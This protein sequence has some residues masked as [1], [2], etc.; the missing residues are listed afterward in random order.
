MRRHH[1][2]IAIALLS[3]LACTGSAPL[4]QPT[5]PDEK[6]A[7]TVVVN[8]PL[9]L[10]VT[11]FEIVGIVGVTLLPGRVKGTRGAVRVQENSGG[12]LC[13]IAITGHA[14]VTA[15][16]VVLHIDDTPRI[17]H[18]AQRNTHTRQY[19]A[20]INGLAPGRYDVYIVRSDR[21]VVYP[22]RHFQNVDVT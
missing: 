3:A 18:S 12:S 7:P 1:P 11:D 14:D 2:I 15:N 17:C 22:E 5:Q 13:G 16:R 19:D 10:T 9:T 21:G 8:G 4:T 6:V 20:T